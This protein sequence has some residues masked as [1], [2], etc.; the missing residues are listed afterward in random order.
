MALTKKTTI[1]SKINREKY[2]WDIDSSSDGRPAL[3]TAAVSS[4]NNVNKVY[5][6]WADGDAAMGT[7]AEWNNNILSDTKSD[8]FEGE[9]VPHVFIYKA[10]NQTPLINGQTYSIN[11]TYNHYQANTNTGGFVYMTSYN[12]SR[13]PDPSGEPDVSAFSGA[14]ILEDS[15]FAVGN[16]TQGNLHSVNANITAVS[17]VVYTTSGQGTKDAHVT[18]TFVYSGPNTN[19]G[20]A[21][22]YYGLSIARPN[23]VAPDSNGAG[24]WT[25]GS[26]QTTVDVNGSGATSIQLMPS[27]IIHGEISGT[28]F[29]DV[30]GDGL[31]DAD[32]TD[33]LLGT[34]DDEVGLA[35]WTIFL[36][37][38]DNGQLDAGEAFMV[39][40]ADDPLTSESEAGTY[41]FS[42]TPDANPMDP[43]DDPYLVRE[44]QQQGWTQTSANPGPIQITA[45]HPTESNVN[46]GNQLQMP[47]LNV[48]KTFMGV[49]LGDGDTLADAAGDVLNYR[50]SVTNTGNVTLTNVTVVDPLTGQ[51][52]SGVTLAPGASQDFDSTYMLTQEDLDRAGNAGP[53]GDIDN[54]ATADSDQTGPSDA[55]AEVPLD[56]S[57]ALSVVKNFVDV[58]G[59]DGDTLADA[60][61]D[62]LNYRVSVTN[63]GN[64]TLTNVTV[65]DPLTGQNVSG[66][67][68]APGASQDFDSTYMLTQEDLDRAGNAGPDGD[69]DNTATADSDQTGPSDA[70]AQVPLVQRPGMAV[71]KS[72]IDVTGGNGNTVADAAGDV[73]NYEVRVT[74]TGNQTLTG[75]TVVDPLTGQNISGITLA[76]GQTEFLYASY[77]L[78][79]ADLDNNGGGDGDI[80]NTATAD[81]SQTDPVSSTAEAPILARAFLAMNKVFM[82][83]DDT[84][85]NANGYADEAGEVLNYEVRLTNTGNVTLTGVTVQDPSTGLDQ[86]IASLAPGATA[87]LTADYTLTQDDLDSNGG[88][89]ADVDNLAFADSNQTTQIFDEESAAIVRSTAIQVN[90]IFINITGG[91]DNTVADAP[92]DVINYINTVTNPGNVTLTNVTLVDPLT[93]LDVLLPTL[94]PG[95]SASYASSYTLTQDDLDNNGNPDS[96]GFI[97]NTVVADSAETFS[98]ADSET[99]PVLTRTGLQYDQE[100]LS[101][102]G[103][104]GNDIADAAGDVLNYQ[105]TVTNF[106]NVTLT[107]LSLGD[108]LT[109]LVISGESLAPASFR[110][111]LGSYTLTQADLDNNA[112]T[113]FLSNVSFADSDQTAAVYDTEN[114]FLYIDPEVTL[115]KSVSVDGGLSWLD[116]N[117]APGPTLLASGTAPLFRFEVSNSGN[118]T[119]TDVLLADPDFDLNGAEAGANLLIGTLAPEQMFT[120]EVEG[121]YEAGANVNIATVT[122]EWAGVSSLADVDA[123]HYL[124]A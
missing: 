91:N 113:G 7:K 88:G 32:G 5:Q 100:L 50:V 109:G 4:N 48:S 46:F 60:A 29:S 24:S 38:N 9:V 1:L 62:V 106:G 16:G 61:G 56:Y 102:T 14:L 110:T 36:D 45:M 65:V 6:H 28:K 79:Q 94:A 58:S 115:V 35:G 111:Y 78:T 57:P 10:S 97:D 19:N 122:A 26:L 89:D 119:L 39:T 42:V 93:G 54:T 3:P 49:T 90:K 51:N 12:E 112:G 83:V 70:S 68:L 74:N 55:S 20:F 44:V 59:G 71:E 73:L 22:I 64:V 92:G 69:I 53:D 11:V 121:I 84:A 41:L 40:L 75:V 43:D 103:G 34:P 99:V 82:G 98:V 8:Y 15:A 18:I 25:G 31:R 23:E 63:T 17:D 81:S 33:N 52:V 21:E 86:T 2:P 67:T 66:V 47:E 96:N 116:A 114:A 104:N 118:M 120:L 30:N 72:F 37:T 107:G 101:V 117:S 13:D 123:A 76:P 77:T 105:F 108:S 85:G 124:G 80:D 95:D 87:T 27:A